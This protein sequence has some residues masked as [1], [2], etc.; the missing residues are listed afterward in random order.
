[1]RIVVHDYAGHPFQVQ[2]SRYLASQGHDVLHMYCASTS[3]TPQGAL[4]K[5]D[6]DPSTFEAIGI[7]LGYVIDKSNF[8]KVFFVD[9]PNHARLALEQVERFRPDVI[10]AANT[11]LRINS[12]F[13][14]YCWRENAKFVFWVQ[15][16]FGEAAKRILGGRWFGVGSLVG[17]Y[18]HS[19]EGKLLKSSDAI[20][21]ISE[22]FREHI[23][24]VK[25]P[26]TVIEN[27]APLEEMP[28]TNRV[29]SWGKKHGL[30]KTRN[31]IYSGTI[32]MKHNPELLVKVAEAF[33]EEADVRTVVISQGRGMDYLKQRKEELG[34]ENLV[35]LPFQPFDDLPEVMGSADVLVA[36]LEPDAGV[37]SVPSK[38]LS[39]LCA[40]RGVL[41]AVPPE[42]L[43]A[44][45][46]ADHGAGRV[47]APTDADGFVAAAREMMA[48]A[49]GLKA[50]GSNARGYAERTFDIQAIGERF[51]DVFGIY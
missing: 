29:N 48:D 9:D 4:A 6:S 12:A 49:D 20:V 14:E 43:A 28:L 45:I 2:L 34:L 50:M 8:A 24:Q 30:D 23:P 17:Q 39:Y 1:M 27:W 16:L 33:R 31:F 47:V 7:D 10:L 35:L 41:L 22:A 19:F 3:A 5:T 51:V 32:G 21:L 46:V 44:R 25:C 40:G 38:V 15:D 37:F 18:M 13:Q 11:P 42:N 26:V 36:I